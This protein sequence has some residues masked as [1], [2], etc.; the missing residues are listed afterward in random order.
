MLMGLFGAFSSP[1]CY[2]LIADYF[3][4]D[5]RTLANAFFTSASFFG[6]AFAN[7][8]NILIGVVGWR[9]CYAI[10]GI[11]G[12]FAITIFSIFVK[13][14]ERGKFDPKN[15]KELQKQS[16]VEK[17]EEEAAD[18]FELAEDEVKPNPVVKILKGILLG[19]KTLIENPC[20]RWLLIGNLTLSI[21]QFL[22]SYSL[23]TY[24]NFYNRTK[25]FSILNAFCIIFGGCTSCLASGKI[26]NK[27]DEKSY[28]A[29]SYVSGSMCLIAVPLCSMMFLVENFYFGV[30]ILFL[31]DLLC[32]GYYAPVMSMIQ[33]TI[34]PE[35]KGAAIGA[36][37]FAN[38]Y[39]Q[40]LIS[41]LIG[42]IVTKDDLDS[43]Q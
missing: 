42:Y 12:L 23:T 26:A 19:L 17:A 37:G 4:P 28:R 24:F 1:I 40:A 8:S 18:Q 20:T 15:L 32:L 14:P 31:Y 36:F 34:E 27:L 5:R 11:Y 33:G 35:N 16:E 39:T 7:L 22:F 2:S 25:E 29:K 6:I 43:N 21:S 10:C 3:P 38:N 9:W 13:E 41:L 30:V